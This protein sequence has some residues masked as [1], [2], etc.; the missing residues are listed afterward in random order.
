MVFVQPPGAGESLYRGNKSPYSD[1][2]LSMK[3]LAQT[4]LFCA[5]V[6]SNA[7]ANTIQAEHITE[8]A[9]ERTKADVTYDG[10][11]FSIAYPQGDVPSHL[12]VCTDVVIRAYRKLGIDLQQLVHEDM[13]QNF[14]AYPKRWGLRKP[15][16]NIDHRRVPNLET[17]FTRKGFAR[18]IS[19]NGADYLPGDLVTWDL[20]PSRRELPHIGILVPNPQGP[21]Q[22]WVVHNIGAGP[23]LSNSLFSWKITGHFRFL[24]KALK[25]Q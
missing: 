19:K 1:I 18:K 21:G 9:L 22:P 10:R 14:A 17:Y 5:L 24:P 15:D 7:F 3:Y 23:E 25:S 11:Y 8:A 20:D 12:G 4:L 2:V 6:P 13:R 16:R